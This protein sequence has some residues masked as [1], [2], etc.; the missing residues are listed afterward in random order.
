M[1]LMSSVTLDPGTMRVRTDTEVLR[2]V[3]NRA[4]AGLVDTGIR[5]FIELEE[6]HATKKVQPRVQA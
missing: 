6:Q 5:C 3:G 1:A 2:N 4:A